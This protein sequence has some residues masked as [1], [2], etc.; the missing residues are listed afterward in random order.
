[1]AV[2]IVL[3][4]L[5]DQ[6][7]IEL[8]SFGKSLPQPRVIRG[9]LLTNRVMGWQPPSAQMTRPLSARQRQDQYDWKRHALA[10]TLQPACGCRNRRLSRN[11]PTCFRENFRP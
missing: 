5:F 9:R 7:K 11:C 4:V 8:G 10:P 3:G 2:V 1:M 6:G